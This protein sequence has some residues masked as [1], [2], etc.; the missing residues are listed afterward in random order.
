LP[1]AA[2]GQLSSE[3]LQNQVWAALGKLTPKQRAVIVFRYYL[4]M[5][6]AEMAEELDV[7]SGTVKSRLNA[8]RERLR[9][10]LSPV[11]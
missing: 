7:P 4:E 2:V 1:S 5:G 9:Q 3:A 6:E 8:A 10:L 11:W